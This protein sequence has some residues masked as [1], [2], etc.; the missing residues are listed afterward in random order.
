VVF[1]PDGKHLATASGDGLIKLWDATRLDQ[2]LQPRLAPLRAR[3]PGPCVIVAFSPDSQRLV[4]GGADNTVKV[5]DVQTGRELQ[6]LRGHTGDVYTVAFSPQD[7][8][9]WIASGSEDSTVKVWD[10][11]TEQPVR[12]FRGHTSLVCSLA[13]SP[14]GKRLYSGSRDTTVKVWDVSSLDRAGAAAGGK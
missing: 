1:S 8:G 7:G 13:F 3:V 2:E 12:S 5:W 14:D 10:T 4:S 6:T 11:R 9:R